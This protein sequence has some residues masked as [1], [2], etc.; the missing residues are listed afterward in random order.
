MIVLEVFVNRYLAE[1][2]RSEILAPMIRSATKPFQFASAPPSSAN[3]D[4]KVRAISGLVL[5]MILQRLM[6]DEVLENH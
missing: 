2:F 4:M 1:Q 6:G 3:L 5:G